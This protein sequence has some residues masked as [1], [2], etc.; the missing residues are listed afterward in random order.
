MGLV[1]DPSYRLEK[2]G[3]EELDWSLVA[4]HF[5]GRRC[6]GTL[7]LML[8]P[9]WPLSGSSAGLSCVLAYTAMLAYAATLVVAGGC[10]GRESLQCCMN[11][12][13]PKEE[14]CA[15][16]AVPCRWTQCFTS[17][18]LPSCLQ[19]E[20]SAKKVLDAQQAAVD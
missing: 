7:L 16:C 1:E 2:L 13:Q 5:G 14:Q 9:G 10:C 11:K 6:G 8:H 19:P 3:T 17:S 15:G 12:H 18:P 20:R 4:S